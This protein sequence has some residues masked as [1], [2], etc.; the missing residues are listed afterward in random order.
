MEF[1]FSQ[2]SAMLKGHAGEPRVPKE[3]R[4]PK[5]AYRRGSYFSESWEDPR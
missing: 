3:L 4:G 5:Y 2:L 1:A